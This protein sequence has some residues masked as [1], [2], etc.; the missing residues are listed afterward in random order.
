MDLCNIRFCWQYCSYF[1]D[2]QWLQPSSLKM[3]AVRQSALALCDAERRKGVACP[4]K[5]GL[6]AEHSSGLEWLIILQ[7]ALRCMRSVQA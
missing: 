5:E 3:V 4:G 7:I 6:Q 2:T 1:K